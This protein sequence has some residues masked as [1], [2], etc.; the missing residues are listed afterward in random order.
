MR[1]NHSTSIDFF[2]IGCLTHKFMLGKPPWN[3]ESREAYKDDLINHQVILKKN[4]TRENWQNECSD[5]I[6]KC[7]KRKTHERL[8]LNGAG[9]MKNH[10]WFREFDWRGLQ[11]RKIKPHWKPP[12][13]SGNYNKSKVKEHIK[14]DK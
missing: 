3:D 5:F 14:A 6:N 10:I 1:Q 7:I 8:G 12:T 11:H 9:E 2:A 4:D 13:R